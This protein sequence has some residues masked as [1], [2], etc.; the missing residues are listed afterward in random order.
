MMAAIAVLLVP[1]L[2]PTR[3]RSLIGL[4]LVAAA[5]VV[6][7]LVIAPVVPTSPAAATAAV[8]ARKLRGRRCPLVI[9]LGG[10]SVAIHVQ[11]TAG[12]VRERQRAPTRHRQPHQAARQEEAK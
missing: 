6:R 11:P 12:V 2:V 5:V 7:V 10:A 9:V 1:P 8:A 3:P 4:V